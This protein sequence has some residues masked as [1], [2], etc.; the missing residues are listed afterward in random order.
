MGEVYK[1]RDIRLD[2][3]VA[4]KQTRLSAE[5]RKE[6]QCYCFVRVTMPETGVMQL[7]A[8]YVPVI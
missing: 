8:V 6:A 3:I 2:R 1:A 4:V 5:K 7:T